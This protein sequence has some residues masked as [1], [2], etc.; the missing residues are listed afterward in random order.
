MQYFINLDKDTCYNDNRIFCT[1]TIMET[2]TFFRSYKKYNSIKINLYI[3][4]NLVTFSILHYQFGK[5]SCQNTRVVNVFNGGIKTMQ[6]M[7]HSLQNK[8]QD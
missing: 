8:L 5:G 7:S 3:K 1:K 4:Y 6:C 2:D